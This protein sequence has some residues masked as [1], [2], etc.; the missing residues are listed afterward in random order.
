MVE[1]DI[2]YVYILYI[3]IRNKLVF[4]FTVPRE[5]TE[6]FNTFQSIL[7]RF[8]YEI[9]QNCTCLFKVFCIILLAFL[10]YFWKWLQSSKGNNF[11]QLETCRGYYRHHRMPSSSQ[12]FRAQ[13]IYG[14]N[15]WSNLM[16]VYHSHLQWS[17]SKN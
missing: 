3:L 8:L 6:L 1:L 11:Q 7:S 12:Y 10:L 16:C 13:F 2:G 14:Y 17:L 4:K 9:K 15:V 5:P